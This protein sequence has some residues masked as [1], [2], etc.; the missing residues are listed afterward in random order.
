MPQRL[1]ML[2]VALGVCLLPRC[3]LADT[4]VGGQA[5][6]NTDVSWAYTVTSAAATTKQK[7]SGS[8]T[9]W[10]VQLQK[11]EAGAIVTQV[12]VYLNG[13][14]IS[15]VAGHVTTDGDLYQFDGPISAFDLNTTTCTS[16]DARIVVTATR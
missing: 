4:V 3:L 12:R 9:H 6:T 5:P 8:Y 1:L 16:C 2:A 11:N 7:V 15:T 14:T 10:S 13:Q